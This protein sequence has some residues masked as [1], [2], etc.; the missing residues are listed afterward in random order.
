MITA[1]ILAAGVGSRLRPLT[2]SLPKCLVPLRDETILGRMV[3]LLIT[4]GVGTVVVATGFEA[5]KVRAALEGC[6]V[7]VRFVH[8]PDY[9]EVQNVVSFHRALAV[10]PH[11]AVVK[12]DG[13][14]VFEPAVLA[15]LFAAEGE[16]AVAIHDVAPPRAEAMKVESLGGWARSFGKGLD[17][18]RCV[19]E[20]IGIERFGGNA[21]SAVAQAMARA[22]EAGRTGLYYEDTYNEA[23]AGGMPLRCVGVSDLAWTEVDD[24]DDLARARELVART[25]GERA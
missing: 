23:L 19:G 13:D 15:R 12:L 7:P 18:S 10:C 20:S 6:S 21:R 22:V 5:A 3:R 25:E 11:G 14:V 8:N 17:P 4:A 9:A 1:V 24:L 16:A 2:D